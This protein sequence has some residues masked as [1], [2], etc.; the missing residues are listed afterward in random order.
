M[1]KYWV[2][3]FVVTLT[4][5]TVC[6]M[7]GKQLEQV[8]PADLQMDETY[9]PQID[10][11]VN[12]L[13]QA[14]NIPGAVIA[15]GR[16]DRLALLKKWGE[17]QRNPHPEPLTFDTL[18]DLASVGKV[19]ALAP[20]IAM[21]VD[22]GKISYTDKVTKYL[23]EL[24]GKG[25][26]NITVYDF[27][28]HTSGIRDGYS[29]EGTPSD[30]WKRICQVPCKARPGEQFEYSCLG[31]LI[32]GKLVER[33][34]G[35]TYADYTRNHIFLPLG[36]VDTMFHPDEQ[37]RRRT[38]TTQFFDGRWIKGEANDTRSRRMGGGTGN[39]ANISTINDMAVYAS[40]ILNKGKYTTEDGKVQQ[41]FSPETYEKMAASC[42]TPAGT[43]SRGW[44]KR[45][46]KENRGALMSPLALGHGG[47]T[48]TA[49]WIDP[50]FNTF[51]VVLSSRLNINP[52]APNIYPTAAKITDR[53]ID[54]IRDPHNETK[55]RTSV[56]D[57]VLAPMDSSAN[58]ISSKDKGK[59]SFLTG[60]T[61][62]II[63]DIKAC[64][65]TTIPSV[66]NM[67]K[68]GINVKTVFCRDKESATSIDKAC[69]KIGLPVP[70]LCKLF[71][72]TPRRLLPPQI[73]GID[74]LIFDA[75]TSGKGN[76]S[77]ITDLGRAMQT[78]ADNYLSFILMD[79]IN[80]SG[81]N[82]VSG[83][84]SPP[85]SEPLQAFR[86][87]PE[88][89]AMSLGELALMFNSEYRLGL[90]LSVIPFKNT[91][92]DIP[93]TEKNPVIKQTLTLKGDLTWFQYQRELYLIYPR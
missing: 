69:R 31:F 14:D 79:R 27:L 66:V 21:L 36:M 83:D 92:I 25:L 37:R 33:V 56:R 45:S 44:D 82:Q 53:V 58:N 24:T 26:N 88:N 10:L 12:Q 8:S 17:R 20:S 19:V 9:F 5:L 71:E 2:F 85:G 28:T 65:S 23:P 60:R 32:L 90:T 47:W 77:T 55:I 57:S 93:G 39:G 51:V 78:A 84:F 73:K 48:G 11:W 62:G 46:N 80:P 75:V 74:T 15:V 1:K 68:A 63:T 30:I 6:R 41:L 16:G 64:E 86:R 59:Y 89:Y 7:D 22:Q 29:W 18:Y 3:L 52:S 72:L 34:S 61:V 49:I 35:E 67:L 4:L 87:L 38:A 40:V 91:K 81:M 13:M 54:S 42:P 50:A 70:T 76:D 43:R